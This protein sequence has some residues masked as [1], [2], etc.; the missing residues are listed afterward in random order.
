[1]K[2]A[3]KLT[4]AELVDEINMY[5]PNRKRYEKIKGEILF[6]DYFL[7]LGV[8]TLDVDDLEKV[9]SF[10]QKYRGS[11]QMNPYKGNE[12]LIIRIPNR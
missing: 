7:D 11:L 10:C 5:F 6:N 1:M 12:V 2:T 4:L 9:L 8:R 3:D